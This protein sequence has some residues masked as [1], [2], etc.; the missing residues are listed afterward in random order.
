MTASLATRPVDAAGVDAAGA[1]D[2]AAHAAWAKLHATGFGGNSDLQFTPPAP[3]KAPE[4]SPWLGAFGRWLEAMLAPLARM[5]GVSWP[6]LQMVVLALVALALGLLVWKIVAPILASMLEQRR[7]KPP[8]AA[9]ETWVPEARAA[10]ALL[11]DA[12]ALAAQGRFDA[13][14]HL[15]LLRSFD[16]IAAAR[17]EWLLP[18]STAREIAGLPALPRAASEAFAQITRLV[19]QG[20]YALR[21]LDGA[22]WQ[23]ARDAYT[24]FAL[25]NLQTGAA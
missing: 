16:H 2:G 23:A 14:A 19:E 1:H 18:A 5:I 25:Q 15:L 17:P 3:W 21:P 22:G 8:Q 9:Q 10:A 6:V 13:A 12:D 20:R 7:N 11:E 4:P 24:G